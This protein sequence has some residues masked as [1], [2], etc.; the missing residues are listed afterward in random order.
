MIQHNEEME[1]PIIVIE[2]RPEVV[3]GQGEGEVPTIVVE[4]ATE[5]VKPTPKRIRRRVWVMAG[6]VVA[7]L[8]CFALWAGWRYYRDYIH[9]GLPISVTSEQNIAKLQAPVDNQV[10]AEV[11]KTTDSILGVALQFYEMRGL[12]AELSMNEPDTADMDVYLYCRSAD[13]HKDFS[14]IGEMVIDGNQLET[15]DNWR[16]GYFV[17][18][19]DNYA[20]GIARDNKAMRYAR[21]KGGCF[22]RQFILLS[23]RTIPQTFYLHGKVERRA[24]GR[25]ANDKLYYIATSHKETMWDFADA[26]REYGFV[27]AIYI[28]GGYDYNF[29]RTADGSRYDIG[30]ASRYPHKN[31]GRVPWLVFRRR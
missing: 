28:T 25:M 31:P 14:I 10:K 4:R 8:G 9:V 30:D 20:I 22:F 15:V 16:R 17:A 7:V 18:D 3:P 26:L 13:Y 6:A 19:E 27:D 11:V 21:D 12:R 5:E 29:Y 1:K 23:D 2:E 24:I